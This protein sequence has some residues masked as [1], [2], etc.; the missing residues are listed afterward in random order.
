[1]RQAAALAQ[2]GVRLIAYE[3]ALLVEAGHARAFR[4]LVVVTA[5]DSTQLDRLMK[6]DGLTIEQARARIAAQMPLREKLALADHVI[7][8]SCTL[9]EVRTRTNLVLARI[10]AELGIASD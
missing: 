1:M 7:D 6:R 8:T 9:D 10:C 3:A 5:D 4:P 2:T